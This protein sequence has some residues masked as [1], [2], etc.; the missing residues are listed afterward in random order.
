MPHR[1]LRL[2]FAYLLVLIALGCSE[3]KPVS[4]HEQGLTERQKAWCRKTRI[5]MRKEL[6][7]S[8]SDLSVITSDP[9]EVTV[10][11]SWRCSNLPS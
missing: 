11:R 5:S 3:S 10:F 7:C 6:R 1:K 2:S 9:R 8:L 4:V